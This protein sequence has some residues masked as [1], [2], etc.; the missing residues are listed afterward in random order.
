LFACL[1]ASAQ[2]HPPSLSFLRTE[3][4][5][6][7]DERGET[8]LL[9]GVNLGGWLVEEMWMM[10]FVTTPPAQ[11]DAATIRDHVSLWNVIEKRLGVDAMQRM[12]VNLRE[13]WIDEKDFDR[14]AETGLNCVRLPFLCDSLEPPDDL[15]AWLDRAIDWAGA[16]GIYV[17]LDMHGA[18]GRQ[19]KDHCTGQEGIN[20][21]FFDPANIERAGKIW[22]KIATRYRHRPEVAG[23]DLLNEPI[24]APDQG[25][26]DAVH[27]RLYR[28]IRSVDAKHLIF[29]EDGYKGL[30][31]MPNP[32]LAGWKNT[33]LSIH[34]YKF[35]AKN[36][37]DQYDH[38]EKLTARML[39]AQQTLAAP[40]Y[41]GEFNTP[42][43][44]QRNVAKFCATMEDHGWSWT[45]WTY[46]IG[47]GRGQ[48]TTWGWLRAPDLSEKL[49]PFQDSEAQ[50][51]AK[52]SKVRSEN[53]VVQPEMTAALSGR[54]K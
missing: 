21:F 14:I 41:M 16:R 42:Q 11:S 36:P 2:T 32:L 15:F 25:T 20:R 12:R 1:C 39:K 10:P 37:Q 38:L 43:G 47:M 17:I 30:E 28:A 3:G 8:V 40:F 54:L 44:D 4:T 13:A 27:D 46:K 33:V 45:I 9:R 35:D 18:P 50:W 51:Q 31:Q 49:D 52:L 5:R 23:Y 7:V 34:A 6:L 29:I 26:L 19:S 24:G 22:A 53:M 48:K